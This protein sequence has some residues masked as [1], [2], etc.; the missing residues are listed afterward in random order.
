M[1]RKPSKPQ[2]S[3]TAL[4]FSALIEAIQHVHEH[5]ASLAKRAVNLS[6]TLR[7]W[8]IGWYIH[9]YEQGG[10][11]RA[12][13]GESLLERLAERL[14]GIGLDEISPRYLR[15]CR[16]FSTCYPEI[17]R[18]LTA[19]SDHAL[20]PEPIWR[21]LTAK[22][23]ETGKAS[24]SGLNTRHLL[25]HLTFIPAAACSCARWMPLASIRNS[26]RSTAA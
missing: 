6:L 19:K 15:L 8:V 4:D 2:A 14:N 3:A 25:E 1:P 21:S 20:L 16:R 5:S 23:D 9:E 13:Y 12:A 22:F 7:N 18:S 24:E 11:D 10:A 26:W 17:R